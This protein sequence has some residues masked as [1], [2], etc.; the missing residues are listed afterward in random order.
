MN[1]LCLNQSRATAVSGTG[2]PSGRSHANDSGILRPNRACSACCFVPR[3]AKC[4]QAARQVA[5]PTL[6]PRVAAGHGIMG[7]PEPECAPP[8]CS[9][10]AIILRCSAANSLRQR[11]PS[12]L[13]PSRNA[14]WQYCRSAS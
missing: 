2:S 4:T 9:P 7:A 5:K 1:A 8:W 10:V 6:P 11:C 14:F 12:S 13:R 3:Q